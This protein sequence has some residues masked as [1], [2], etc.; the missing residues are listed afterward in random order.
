MTVNPF[1]LY[2]RLKGK[3]ECVSVVVKWLACSLTMQVKGVRFHQKHKVAP[4]LPELMQA[5][6]CV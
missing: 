1:K 5:G 3:I 4:Q 6:I 2:I